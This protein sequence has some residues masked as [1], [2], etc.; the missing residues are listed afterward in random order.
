MTRQIW[1]LPSAWRRNLRARL[2][3][4][5]KGPQTLGPQTSEKS[6]EESPTSRE[7]SLKTDSSRLF[8]RDFFQPDFR[9]TSSVWE[10]AWAILHPRSFLGEE[11]ASGWGFSHFPMCLLA[12]EDLNLLK[13]RFLDKREVYLTNLQNT[14]MAGKIWQK[15]LTC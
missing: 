3:K 5:S 4:S 8:R 1:D 13:K 7:K 15:G 14:R 12:L 2:K 6:L 9:E 11:V 10:K